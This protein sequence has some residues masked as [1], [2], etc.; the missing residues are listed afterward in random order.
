MARR[1]VEYSIPN[2]LLTF[3][4]NSG[5][6]GKDKSASLK[7]RG[8]PINQ[9]IFNLRRRIGVNVTVEDQADFAEAIRAEVKERKKFAYTRA[10][11][12]YKEMYCA[13]EFELAVKESRPA[14]IPSY[15]QFLYW[16]KK[17]ISKQE[18]ISSQVYTSHYHRAQSD[19][20]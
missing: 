14:Q 7:Q 11:E 13:M 12:R 6:R 19:S 9:G 10:Y 5:G 4:S 2:S 18:L 8:R 20:V 3:K 17:L 1:K 16:G 15:D